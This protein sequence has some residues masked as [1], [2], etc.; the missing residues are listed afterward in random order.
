MKKLLSTVCLLSLLVFPSLVMAQFTE[1][2]QGGGF[3]GP[4]AATVTVAEALK[5]ADDAWVTL[6][7]KIEK[8]LGHEKYQFS[9]GTGTIV[10]DIDDKRWQGQTVGPE[11]TVVITGEVDKDFTSLEIEVKKIIKK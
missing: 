1:S 8:Q 7:G 4:T 9:D 2:T 11:D 6:E 3:T 5:M 10:L